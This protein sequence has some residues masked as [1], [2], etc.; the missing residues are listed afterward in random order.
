MDVLHSPSLLSLSMSLLL[1][2]LSQS[3]PPLTPTVTV[4][5]LILTD[6]ANSYSADSLIS[7]HYQTFCYGV[8]DGDSKIGTEYNH[9][10]LP[11]AA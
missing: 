6:T 9:S 10:S 5:R 2:P 1:L 4:L 3:L 7:T 8:F 11:P